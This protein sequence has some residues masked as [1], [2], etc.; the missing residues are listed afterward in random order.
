MSLSVCKSF[1]LYVQ[2]MNMATLTDLTLLEVENLHAVLQERTDRAIAAEIYVGEKT[3]EF[4]LAK[5]SAKI[6]IQA[7]RLASLSASQAGL[8]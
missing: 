7:H 3:V 8:R 5:T 4:Y 2:E 1:L 6:R